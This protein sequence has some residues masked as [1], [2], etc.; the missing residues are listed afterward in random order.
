MNLKMNEP[1]ETG[2]D[3]DNVD[4]AYGSAIVEPKRY[5]VTNALDVSH[6]EELLRIT[7]SKS[8]ADDAKAIPAFEEGQALFK[9][10]QYREALRKYIEAAQL[11]HL[12]SQR[13]L[14]VMYLE[15]LGCNQDYLSA[16]KWLKIAAERNDLHAQE[17]L[18]SMHRRG[19][20]IE[21]SIKT[22]IYWYHRSSE[23]GGVQSTY[24]LATCY[25][26]GEGVPQDSDEATRL[27]MI[28]AE[29]GH[30]DARYHVGVAYELGLG[31]DENT[32]EA[33]DW[34]ILAIQGR[35]TEARIRFWALV[36]E[37]K[38]LPETY[39][40]AKFAERVGLSLN[41][42]I[43]KLKE[44]IRLM[45]GFDCVQ[46]YEYFER[47]FGIDSD[48]EFLDGWKSVL[49]T[50][51][52]CR[53]NEI[54]LD[55]DAN[56]MYKN[57]ATLNRQE[58]SYNL[59]QLIDDQV[60]K[61]LKTEWILTDF[62]QIKV[63]SIGNF[64]RLLLSA[65]LKSR[66]AQYR[67]GW[68]YYE[69]E[70]I[71][72]DVKRSLFWFKKA[73]KLK[74]RDACNWLGVIYSREKIGKEHKRK[75]IKYY[76]KGTKLG[77]PI[78]TYNLANRF[79]YGNG[80]QKNTDKYIKLLTKSAEAGYGVAMFALAQEFASGDKVEKDTQLEEYWLNKAAEEGE[81]DAILTL[82][83][84][85]EELIRVRVVDEIMCEIVRLYVR[86][87]EENCAEALFR[88]I[89]LQVTGKLALVSTY[90]R[91][92]NARH[93]RKVFE[94]LQ[95]DKKQLIAVRE[96]IE[97]EVE[98]YSSLSRRCPDNE[99]SR[100]NRKID[101]FKEWRRKIDNYIEQY[102]LNNPYPEEPEQIG[103]QGESRR[104]RIEKKQSKEQAVSDMWYD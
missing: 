18:A 15:G 3:N 49:W 91:K 22:A 70:E 25:E 90:Y 10:K 14:G 42:P 39:E 17:K 104:K 30:A 61:N 86:A 76:K 78:A 83:K 4:Y 82:A 84:K 80:V 67:L 37:E 103:R 9:E 6:V 87:A 71:E 1:S 95:S 31:V 33:I 101:R 68:Y 35:N 56:Q 89:R 38:F 62:Y 92:V 27:Y 19:L 69:S 81:T 48:N 53:K 52:L 45:T 34:Y 23:L 98:G 12:K 57:R 77:C 41:D 29:R 28:A 2:D 94:D 72:R 64:Y 21:E 26:Q 85:K 43:C 74:D 32:Q 20:G 24:E 11:G 40:E 5:S 96:L 79:E 73:A 55:L 66:F 46:D 100:V 47:S 7:R 13:R 93:M 50:E 102:N 75:A 99:V 88:L 60:T 44:A 8:K 54:D 36:D 65:N 16:L 97:N 51:Y 59:A 63:K 58:F